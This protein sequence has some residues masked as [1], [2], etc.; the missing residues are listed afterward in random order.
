MRRES[1]LGRFDAHSSGGKHG[2]A[3]FKFNP[4]FSLR[5][6]ARKRSSR[7]KRHVVSDE[8]VRVKVTLSQPDTRPITRSDAAGGGAYDLLPAWEDMYL[9]CLTAST[10]RKLT[11]PR[12]VASG[13]ESSKQSIRAGTSR[14]GGMLLSRQQTQPVESSDPYLPDWV[15]EISPAL[16]LR[17]RLGQAELD[18]DPQEHY[19]LVA[20]PWGPGVSDATGA[21]RSTTNGRTSIAGVGNSWDFCITLHAST[22]VQLSPLDSDKSAELLGQS[23]WSQPTTEQRRL[24]QSLRPRQ[25]CCFICDR[26]FGH[27]EAHYEVPEGQTHLQCYE[28]YRKKTARRCLECGGAVL[29]RY[30]QLEEDDPNATALRAKLN[31][32][33]GFDATID[34]KHPLVLHSENGCYDRYRERTA[35][36]CAVC[37]GSVL[38]KYYE[39]DKDGGGAKLIIHAEGDCYQQYQEA[40]A[41]RCLVCKLPVLGSYYDV[42]KDSEQG[43]V[44]ADGPCH[45]RWLESAAPHCAECSEPIVGSSYQVG[46]HGARVQVHADGHCLARWKAR[47]ETSRHTHNGAASDDDY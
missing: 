16:R 27:G 14:L 10:Y 6:L 37:G 17:R 32:A 25:A 47:Q 34:W 9:Y 19:V 35:P 13:T 22:E 18:L 28:D 5:M 24:M 21:E 45:K 4:A 1:V 42:Q 30:H 41:E 33:H 31:A 38:S 29:G 40:T 12:T 43:K 8:R 46:A 15:R 26:G 36:R 39:V 7:G 11:A 23:R 20:C 3:T 2:L 44:H